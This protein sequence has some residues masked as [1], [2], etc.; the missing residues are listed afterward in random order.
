MNPSLLAKQKSVMSLIVKAA[1]SL[2]VLNKQRK[3][4][5]A[6]AKEKQKQL[7]HSL[8]KDVGQLRQTERNKRLQL[9]GIQEQKRQEITSALMLEL[10]Q[11][12]QEDDVPR[13]VNAIGKILD[14]YQGIIV[15]R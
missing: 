14:N 9:Y 5:M 12:C 7:D 13:Y 11:I 1:Q 3:E 8:S 15:I 4:A 10:F 2:H 6:E